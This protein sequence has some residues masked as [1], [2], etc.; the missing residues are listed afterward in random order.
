MTRKIHITKSRAKAEALQA[1]ADVANR[2]PGPGSRYHQGKLD[3]FCPACRKFTVTPWP[4]SCVSCGW[5]AAAH[6]EKCPVGHHAPIHEDGKGNFAIEVEVDYSEDQNLTADQ[7]RE[8]AAA[9][10]AAVDWEPGPPDGIPG[11][12]RGDP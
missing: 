8:W 4:W 11:V 5:T 2:T 12:G 1:I 10:A 7:K 3:N 9:R 6:P